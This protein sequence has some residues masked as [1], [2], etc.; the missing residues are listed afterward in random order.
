MSSAQRTQC[1]LLEF[2]INDK[3]PDNFDVR[4]AEFERFANISG[5][6]HRWCERIDASF[7]EFREEARGSRKH[8]AEQVMLART[9]SAPYFGMWEGRG[10]SAHQWCKQMVQNHPVPHKAIQIILTQLEVEPYVDSQDYS[11]SR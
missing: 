8:F 4:H 3:I 7:R 9:R 11:K 5:A 2:V 1:E 10:S 6:Y